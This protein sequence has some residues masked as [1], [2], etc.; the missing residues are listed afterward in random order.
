[1]ALKVDHYTVLE[2]RSIKD[3]WGSIF[4]LDCGTVCARYICKETVQH[5]FPNLGRGPLPGCGLFEIELCEWWAKVCMCSCSSTCVSG[6]PVGSLTCA[7]LYTCQTAHMHTS[8]DSCRGCVCTRMLAHH[9]YSQVPLSPSQPG[10]Q[11][12]KVRGCWCR[13]CLHF[14]LVVN[15]AIFSILGSLSSYSKIYAQPQESMEK[16]HTVLQ[17]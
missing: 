4:S 17:D 1:M 7:S 16:L 8:L 11:T 2:D 15:L 9:L 13:V 10:C 3:N 14:L 5:S 12:A 6:G